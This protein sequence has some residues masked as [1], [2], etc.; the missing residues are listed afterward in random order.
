MTHS[1]RQ[2]S[3]RAFFL[4]SSLSL[5][6]FQRFLAALE[7]LRTF[8][9]LCPGEAAGTVSRST[10]AVIAA[11]AAFFYSLDLRLSR[12]RGRA[13][14]KQIKLLSI[15]SLEYIYLLYSLFLMLLLVA[16]WTSVGCLLDV[17]CSECWTDAPAYCY[18][19]FSLVLMSV[20]FER[21][22]FVD[23]CRD[24]Y[25]RFTLFFDCKVTTKTPV[26]DTRKGL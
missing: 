25:S 11:T 21:W 17:C 19:A 15:F 23:F 3:W 5:G 4:R 10:E 14:A 13:S 8:G 9:S 20:I 18:R 12:E 1:I 7:T 26:S 24:F 2:T 22:L 16:C 6:D